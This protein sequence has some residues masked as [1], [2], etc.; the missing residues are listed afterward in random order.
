MDLCTAVLVIHDDGHRACLDD[1][2]LSP[3]PVRHDWRLG[4]GE[5]DEPCRGCT[6]A[7]APARPSQAA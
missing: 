6:P 5:F 3:D 7:A 4:C 1:S 2:C